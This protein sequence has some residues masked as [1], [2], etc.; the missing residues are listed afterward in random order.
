MNS[1]VQKLINGQVENYIFPFLWLHGESEDVL[2]HYMKII[3][4]SNIRA[5]CV[6][7]RPHPDFCG[8]SWWKDMDVILDEARNRGM[9]VWILDDSHFPTGFA[10]GAMKEQP[11]Q[12]CRQSIC[13]HTY[14]V[15]AGENFLIPPE[16]LMHPIPFKKNMIEE[17][18]LRERQREFAD[19]SL[20]SVIAVRN[21][22]WACTINLMPYVKD[23]M[24]SWKV[25]DGEWNIFLL[26]LSRNQGYHRSYINMMDTSSCKVLLDAVYEPHY[27][28]YSADFGTT[29]AGFFSDEPE[30]GNG[31]MY[32]M[33]DEFGSNKDYPWSQELE[34]ELRKQFEPEKF[35]YLLWDNDAKPEMKAKVRYSY[36]NTVTQLVKRDFSLQI[37]NWC[38]K[39]GVQYIGHL[40]E[41][42]NHH[43]RTGSSLGHYFRGLAGQDMAGIDDIGGQVF[44]Q[45]EDLCYGK[46]TLRY[47]DGEFYH[48]LLGKLAS[49]AAAIE[50]LK[51][52]NSV[53]E[54]F[55]NYGWSE[56][57]RL[58]KYLVDHF[59]VRGINHFVP[60]AFS[61]KK[62]PDP[63]CPPHFYANG[64]NPQYRHFGKLMS[65]VNR[66][67]TLISGG[68]HVAPIGILYH[69]EAD[70]CGKHMTDDKVGHI[71]ADRQIEY[72]ILPVDIFN[73][74]KEYRMHINKKTLCVNTQQYSTVI[75]PYTQFITSALAN[76]IIEMK[77]AGIKVLFIED[78]P[79]GICDSPAEQNYSVSDNLKESS[80]VVPLDNLIGKLDDL[81]VCELSL[82]PK[83][84]RIRYLHYTHFDGMELWMFVN[85]GTEKYQGNIQF[86]AIKDNKLFYRYDA[87]NN[88]ILEAEF[89]TQGILLDIEPLHSVLYIMEEKTDVNQIQEFNIYPWESATVKEEILFEQEW[90]RSICTSIN[91]PN[92]RN[93]SVVSIPDRLSEEM[94]EFSGYARYEN[95]FIAAHRKRVY[96]EISDAAEGVEVFLN[97]KS[98]GIQIVPIYRYDI[99]EYLMEGRNYLSIEV[100][101]TLERELAKIPDIMGQTKKAQ[102]F[103]GIT[104][105]VHIFCIADVI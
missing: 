49:S 5:V 90:S 47:R 16:E 103:S 91:Y 21:D 34:Q 15:H 11:D 95:T 55:G 82:I 28:R 25:P 52:G 30:L 96:L 51:K 10:N 27:A 72:D 31:H 79:D 1:I 69:A 6:E 66:V 40:I 105:T 43:S 102:S 94:P 71:L 64:Y 85:E 7:S 19:D 42:N 98:L 68:Y 58:E 37:G 65:Y 45:G 33:D 92:F 87:W 17:F 4:E 32:D 35:L 80:E 53:C 62:F 86:S 44:P 3:Y 73:V 56:G 48:Y 18:A 50:P 36:M 13:C 2:R 77:K 39:H 54:I 26:H 60:H 99:T 101:T 24:L 46:G 9:K 75:I 57:I 67:C 63:D 22:T 14:R 81:A 59:L 93:K 88:R 74:P 12:L 41:D 97:R 29:I 38:R 20:F 76:A 89:E 70:W 100:A 83:N 78:Y 84:D 61:P 23:R 104:G 8:E